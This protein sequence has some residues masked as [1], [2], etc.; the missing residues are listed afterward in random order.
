MNKTLPTS[1]AV[2]IPTI[3]RTLLDDTLQSVLEQTSPPDEI[4]VFDN[5][6]TGKVREESRWH[7]HPQILWYASDK[8]KDIITSWNTAVSFAE[9]E[10]IYVLGDDDL[11]LPDF[12]SSIRDLLEQGYDMIYMPPRL[13]DKNG[14][15]VDAGVST[16]VKGEM[17]FKQ[18]LQHFS[19]GIDYPLLLGTQLFSQKAFNAVKGYKAIIVNAL[20]MDHLFYLEIAEASIYIFFTDKA[21]WKYRTGVDDWSG[22]IKDVKTILKL[23]RQFKDFFLK[24]NEIAIRGNTPLK[25]SFY[26]KYLVQM[27]QLAFRVSFSWGQAEN[28]TLRL[29]QPPFRQPRK[30]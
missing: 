17:S 6:G 3:G 15:T 25:R 28:R 13:M 22:K 21:L 12:V 20:A 26:E 18:I 7:A 10:Y 1:L 14:K 23:G 2:V 16:S 11:L 27:Q 24:I 29:S 19:A 9:S 5:S 30:A 8:K 4:I